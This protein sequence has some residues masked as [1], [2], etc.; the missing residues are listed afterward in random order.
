MYCVCSG[1]GVFAPWFLLA[2]SFDTLFLADSVAGQYAPWNLGFDDV[3]PL[4]CDA[5]GGS[6]R[7]QADG[8]SRRP[9]SGR[10]QGRLEYEPRLW[11]T[12]LRSA[13]RHGMSTT[14]RSRYWGGVCRDL[15]KAGHG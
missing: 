5:M 7:G 6:T 15:A 11:D 4:R 12:T 3:V 10:E 1:R 8:C 13:A 14:T 9:S 2:V